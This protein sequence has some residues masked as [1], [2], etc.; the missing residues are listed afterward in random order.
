MTTRSRPLPYMPR[1][2][3]KLAAL[4]FDEIGI[5]IRRGIDGW[6]IIAMINGRECFYYPSS[7]RKEKEA[8]D[9]ISKFLMEMG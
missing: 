9:G 6:A 3:R 2:S 8:V 1:L 7:I 4:G 5:G